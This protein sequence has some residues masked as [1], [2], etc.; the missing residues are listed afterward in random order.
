MNAN[1]TALS[2]SRIADALRASD[3]LTITHCEPP[4]R[5]TIRLDVDGETH[6]LILCPLIPY[7]ELHDR[8]PREVPVTDDALAAAPLAERLAA[9]LRA[10][11]TLGV[12]WAIVTFDEDAVDFGLADGQYYELSLAPPSEYG[13]W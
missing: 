1:T 7:P 2:M 8:P 9:A 12:L 6:T 3:I 13:C 10:D 11:R 5:D 4:I